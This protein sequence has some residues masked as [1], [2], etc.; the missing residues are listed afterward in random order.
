MHKKQSLLIMFCSLSRM[1][2]QVSL[3]CELKNVV[4][5]DEDI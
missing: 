1:N 3:L 5:S 4:L 2:M